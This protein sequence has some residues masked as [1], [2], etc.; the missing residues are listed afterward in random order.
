MTPTCRVLYN[1]NYYNAIVG[2]D[3][4]LYIPLD[5]LRKNEPGTDDI[6]DAWMAQRPKTRLELRRRINEQGRISTET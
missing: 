6:F 2:E 3:N 1:G 5:V 4:L